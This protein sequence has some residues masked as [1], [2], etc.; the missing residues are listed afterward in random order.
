MDRSLTRAVA[1]L[2]AVGMILAI[3]VAEASH[4]RHRRARHAVRYIVTRQHADGSLPG[5]LGLTADAVVAMGAARRAPRALDKA[6]DYLEG[7]AIDD[8]STGEKAKVVLAMVAGG[9]DPRDVGGHDLIQEIADDQDPETGQIGESTVAHA[10]AVLGFI[11]ADQPVN[12]EAIDWLLD[13]QCPD[14]GWQFD[15]AFRDGSEDDHCFDSTDPNDFT[16][17]DTNTTSYAFQA[18]LAHPG[19]EPLEADPFDYFRLAKDPVKKGWRYSHEAEL[20]GNP[21]YTDANSTALVIQTYAADGRPPPRSGRRALDRLQYALCG[22]LDGAFA[23][24]WADSDGDG[25]LERSP[26]KS[27]ARAEPTLEPEGSTVAIATVGAVPGVLKR[28]FPIG[29]AEVTKAAPRRA[30]C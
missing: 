2:V 28:P 13:A 10:L 21:V 29:R 16:T 11:A 7:P 30:S 20:F 27:D 26:T 12:Q 3:P 18:L 6:L 17:S 25:D 14:G 8:A 1:A 15:G 19:L 22:P 23:Y 24:T 4:P 9:R 5:G